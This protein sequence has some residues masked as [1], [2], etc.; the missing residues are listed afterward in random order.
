MWRRG[1]LSAI[2]VLALVAC[3]GVG[4][5]PSGPE[6]GEEPESGSTRLSP[7]APRET[8]DQREIGIYAAA[9]EAM[10]ATEPYDRLFVHDRPCRARDVPV[11]DHEDVTNSELTEA[12]EEAF[13]NAERDALLAD[14]KD[15]PPIRFVDDPQPVIERIFQGEGSEEP[16]SFD[17]VIQFAVPRGHGDRVEVFASAYC[18]GLCGHWMTLVIERTAQGWQATGTTGPVAIS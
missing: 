9:I 3:G 17:G 1:A 11:K 10:A 14:L 7:T 15:L 12:C 16:R 18:G 8:V 4:N 2:T 13:S 5:G 6:A